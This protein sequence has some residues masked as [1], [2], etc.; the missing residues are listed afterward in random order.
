LFQTSFL[1]AASAALCLGVT[2]S[3]VSGVALNPVRVVRVFRDFRL[4]GDRLEALSYVISVHQRSSAVICL[5][6]VCSLRLKINPR[7]LAHADLEIGA[8][9]WVRDRLEAMSYII[10]V[11][12]RPS[13]VKNLCGF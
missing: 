9:I 5:R 12:Q 11:H 6:S 4:N 13:A 7:P 3:R 10:S 2:R 8:P 1:V